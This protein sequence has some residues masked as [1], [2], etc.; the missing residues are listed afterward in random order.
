MKALERIQHLFD[1]VRGAAVALSLRLAPSEPQRI[2][3][4]TIVLGVVCGLAAV[5]FHEAIR[6]AQA[7]VI[8]RTLV[9]GPSTWIP[10]LLLAPTP[11]C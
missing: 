2:F 9:G 1:R 10:A 3:G 4:L 5:A 11:R 8:D 6:G 7:L